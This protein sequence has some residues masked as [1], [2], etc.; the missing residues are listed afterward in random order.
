[1]SGSI[2]GELGIV[3]RYD[4]AAFLRETDTVSKHRWLITALIFSAHVAHAQDPIE[5]KVSLGY[6]STSGNTDSSTVNAAFN[7]KLTQEVWNHEFDLTAIKADTSGVTTAEAYT[8]GYTARRDIGER[9]YLFG[10][11]S[12]QQ[13][14]FS[15]YTEQTSETVGYGRHLVM[16]ERHELNVEA[17]GGLRQAELLN[18]EKTDEGILRAALDYEWTLSETTSFSQSLVIENGS[19]NTRTE[20][21]SEL[22]ANII[23]NIALVLSYRLRN[24]SDVLPG[25]EKTDRFTS[26]SL[27]YAF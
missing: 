10:A 17:G 27:E 8:A 16:T 2:A 26:V 21:L 1:M 13:D 11:L 25:T 12:W 14:E 15:S 4:G 7:L 9:S 5:G 18:G 6:I 24:N 23:G 22:R 20:S 19:S 3:C